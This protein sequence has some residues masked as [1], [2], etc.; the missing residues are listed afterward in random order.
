MG[1]KAGLLNNAGM[2]SF[3]HKHKTNGNLIKFPKSFSILC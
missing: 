2:I 1:E 3:I